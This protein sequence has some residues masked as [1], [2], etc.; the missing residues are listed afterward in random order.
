MTKKMWFVLLIGI[1]I[2]AYSVI[3]IPK[4]KKSNQKKELWTFSSL[5]LVGYSL[6][7]AQTM[8]APIP[9]PLDM[10]TFVYK[11]VSKV[12]FALMS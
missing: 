1:I 12:L 9:N 3:E 5:L 11:P 8:N 4:F 6:L 10:I 7:I 2:L